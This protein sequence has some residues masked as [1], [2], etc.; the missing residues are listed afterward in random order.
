M[1]QRTKRT[2]GHAHN[3]S[4]VRY[5]LQECPTAG[6]LWAVSFWSLGNAAEFDIDQFATFGV[7]SA[8]YNKHETHCGRPYVTAD[9]LCP[10]SRFIP[11]VLH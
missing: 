2:C 6:V 11:F 1:L 10:A 9:A 8:N 3:F 4:S 5:R 7:T